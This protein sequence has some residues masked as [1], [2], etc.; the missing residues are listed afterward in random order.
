VNRSLK[1]LKITFG[2]PLVREKSLKVEGKIIFNTPEGSTNISL[3]N[4]IRTIT[5]QKVVCEQ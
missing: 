4:E 5:F 2:R 1:G 3:Q